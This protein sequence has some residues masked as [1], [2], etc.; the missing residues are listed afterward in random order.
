MRI[1]DHNIVTIPNG[2]IVD[3][4]DA[5]ESKLFNVE[6]EIVSHGL[7]NGS[8]FLNSGKWMIWAFGRGARSPTQEQR[9]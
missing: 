2:C 6:N 8:A 1:K 5:K 9:R 4:T 3:L 7:R